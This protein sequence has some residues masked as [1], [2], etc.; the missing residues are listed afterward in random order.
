[1]RLAEAHRAQWRREIAAESA[2]SG[3]RKRRWIDLVAVAAVAAA[4]HL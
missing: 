4:S 2:W 1:M 3:E